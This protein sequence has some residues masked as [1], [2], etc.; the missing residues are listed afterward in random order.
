MICL[1]KA[2]GKPPFCLPFRVH[3]GAAIV[4]GAAPAAHA[5]G[6]RGVG[7][8]FQAL[9]L[10]SGA[11]LLLLALGGATLLAW[12]LVPSQSGILQRIGQQ[13]HPSLGAWKGKEHPPWKGRT[14]SMDA[15]TLRVL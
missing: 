6:R 9:V 11:F 13:K 10:F 3:L 1:G 2:E 15:R 4:P 8:F 12:L 5:G 7:K 14:S